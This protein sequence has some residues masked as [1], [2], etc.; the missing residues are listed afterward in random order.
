LHQGDPLVIPVNE[1]L[2]DGR[3]KEY[4]AA[5]IDTGWV[6]SEGPF[7]TRFE[8]MFASFCGVR[9]GVAVANGTAA[10]E[11]ALYGVGIGRGDEVILPSFTIISCALACLRLGAVPVL[12]DIDPVTWTMDVSVIEAKI[13]PK[14]KAIMPVHIYGHPVDMDEVFRLADKYHLKI[15]EDAAEAHGAA[16]FSKYKG[17]AWLKCGAMGDVAAT[18]FYANKIITTGEGGMVVTNDDEVAKRA[19]SY[20]NLCF[21]PLE[22]F[23]H[24]QIGYNFRMSNLQAA[25]GV[26][27]M[28]Q[29]ERFIGIKRQNAAYYE[30]A[31][32]GVE[33]VQFMKSMPWAQPVYWMCAVELAVPVQK[34]ARMLMDM[35][36]NAGVA[37]RPFFKGLHLQPALQ[38]L[39]F[40][41]DESYP[42]TE[43][44]YRRGFYLP[45]GLA[46]THAQMD[47]VVEELKN[48]LKA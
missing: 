1:P 23:H 41:K 12:V 4:L 29:V 20:R 42:Y 16:Y 6:S 34:D 11:A 19:A 24:E 26:A 28:E 25:V 46:L 7:V 43:N 2:F 32:E 33:G 3:E 48:A 38:A 21:I 15:V 17:G 37:T 40:F 27:Q 31:L 18:S 35:L 44:A 8:E 9:Y 10:I 47:K 13:T 30:A 36:R 5:C 39:G 45:S 14:T 22:R